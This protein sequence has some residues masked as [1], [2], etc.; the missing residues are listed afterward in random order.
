VP[1][2]TPHAGHTKSS[3]ACQF[4]RFQTSSHTP[5]EMGKMQERQQRAGLEGHSSALP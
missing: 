2:G 1:G 4:R 3:V 5:E